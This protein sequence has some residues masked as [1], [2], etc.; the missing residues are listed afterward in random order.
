MSLR[1]LK[2]SIQEVVTP[3]EEEV[4]FVNKIDSRVSCLESPN[5]GNVKA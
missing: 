3:G 1:R 5:A 2:L 4:K